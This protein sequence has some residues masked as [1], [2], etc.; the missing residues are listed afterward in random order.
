MTLGALIVRMR[1]YNNM[2]QKQLA[3]AMGVKGSVLSRW[4]RDERIPHFDVMERMALVLK[5]RL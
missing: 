5:C 4:E 1:G 2:A 3:A